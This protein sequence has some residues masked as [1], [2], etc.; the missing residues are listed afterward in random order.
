M[1]P[2]SKT[3]FHFRQFFDRRSVSTVHPEVWGG[4]LLFGPAMNLEVF[5]RASALFEAGHCFGLI[6][7]ILGHL[8]VGG[9]FAAGDRQE[10]GIRNKN[11]MV[12]G[13][14]GRALCITNLH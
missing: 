4:D 5:G 13:H 8:P 12:P 14:G 1:Q 10:A 6:D 3:G 9:P 11:R 7:S 2:F